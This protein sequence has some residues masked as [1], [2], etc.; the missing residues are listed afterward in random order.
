M[1]LSLDFFADT[2]IIG[3]GLLLSV[4]RWGLLILHISCPKCPWRISGMSFHSASRK[5]RENP[6]SQLS[7][8]FILRI[9][10]WENHPI[11]FH[12][13]FIYLCSC[14]RTIY[15]PY[16][17]KP[18]ELLTAANPN[19][20]PNPNPEVLNSSPRAPLLCIF[21]MSLFVNTWFW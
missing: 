19:P 3:K 21:C 13:L 11:I 18:S 1:S 14:N 16:V 20:N 17:P 7:L 9:I 12:L 10:Y 6:L 8:C 2:A 15:I 4:K 5:N